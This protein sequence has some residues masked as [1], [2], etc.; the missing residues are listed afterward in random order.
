MEKD[1]HE[2]AQR[3]HESIVGHIKNLKEGIKQLVPHFEAYAE[4]V[5]SEEITDMD[6]IEK[7][8]DSMIDFCFE[9]EVLIPYKKILKKIYPRDPDLV[10]SHID[11]YYDFHMDDDEVD[12]ELEG[13]SLKLTPIDKKKRYKEFLSI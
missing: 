10:E 3:L 5:I 12:M 9:D 4:K 2:E 11:I 6:A 8:L 1:E 13:T 7:Q